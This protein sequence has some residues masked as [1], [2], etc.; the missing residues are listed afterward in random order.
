VTLAAG[1]SFASRRNPHPPAA[2]N[3]KTLL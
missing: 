1:A 3:Q 2:S